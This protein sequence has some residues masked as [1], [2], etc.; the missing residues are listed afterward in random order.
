MRESRKWA[1]RLIVFSVV[2]WP[3]HGALFYK[4][5]KKLI[6][7]VVAMSLMPVFAQ[8]A[9]T[10]VYDGCDYARAWGYTGNS[11]NGPAYIYG[12]A[13]SYG[14]YTGNYSDGHSNISPRPSGKVTVP[15]YFDAHP[16]VSLNQ[17]SYYECSD[18]TD[19]TIPGPRKQ[20]MVDYSGITYLGKAAFAGCSSMTNI[21]IP[22]SVT[23]I[24]DSTFSGCSSLKNIEIPSSVTYIGTNG[25]SGCKSLAEIVVPN[26]VTTIR[27][28][29]FS[30]CSGLRRVVL[31]QNLAEIPAYAFSDCTNLAEIVIPETVTN[32]G[33]YAFSGCKKLK[34]IT[35]PR[36]ITRIEVG[37]FAGCGSLRITFPSGL[38]EIGNGAFLGCWWLDDFVLPEGL[39][40][41]GVAAFAGCGVW[42]DSGYIMIPKTVEYIGNGAFCEAFMERVMVQSGIIGEGAFAN[43]YV[44]EVILSNGVVEIGAMAF[45]GCDELCEIS[46]PASVCVVGERAFYGQGEGGWGDSEY[47]VFIDNLNWAFNSGYMYF[48][49]GFRGCTSLTNVV[50]GGDTVEAVKD[51]GILNNWLR[52]C[53]E[54]SW[55]FDGIM[56]GGMT[57]CD[58]AFGHCENLSD[59]TIG[60]N[61]RVINDNGFNGC[62]RLRNLKIEEA[63]VN[64]ILATLLEDPYG[65]LVTCVTNVTPELHIGNMAFAYCSSLTSVAIPSR[66]NGIGDS[67]FFAC[68]ALT[69]LTLKG[70][71]PDMGS[72]AFGS[73]GSGCTAYVKRG[74]TGWGVDIPGT[75]QGVNIRY[76]TPE[77]EIAAA[78]EAGG[79]T[80]EVD[81]GELADVEVASG[82]TLVVKGENLD[83][84]ALAAKITPKPHEAGQNVSL[85]K[86]KAE[87]VVGG[88]AL[89]VGLDEE[90]VGPDATAAEIVSATNMAAFDAAA[91]GETVGVNLPSAKPGLYYGIAAASDIAGLAEAAANVPLVRAGAD[92][93]T[94]PVVRPTGG[95]AF[96]KVVVSDRAR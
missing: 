57:I 53:V 23:Y 64:L 96:F 27:D 33:R 66:V 7:L 38:K 21:T 69:N 31:P 68:R 30:Y 58:E 51:E 37:T 47:S 17:Y 78:N 49:D 34:S 76:L 74:S 75:W 25:F 18:I 55:T 62:Y 80:V 16:V 95:T 43:S 1:L 8:G 5:T 11:T 91:D 94:V 45:R 24:G 35:L 52:S 20:G 6:M 65:D 60:A 14:Y 81:A 28:S 90:A 39:E 41:I 86:V 63:P 72:S 73:V 56:I 36:N 88:V 26:S 59:V 40:T 19:V 82:V 84:D 13:P 54:W 22:Q 85:Y 92:G 50:L 93:V 48:E 10:Y 3:G 87:S 32:I 9:G 67:A 79:G 61:V 12:T 46:I 83:A 70:N 44:S 29:A 4:K 89:A 2:A 42:N 15:S 71:A 77:V